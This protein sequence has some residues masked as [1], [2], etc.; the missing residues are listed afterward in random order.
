MITTNPSLQNEKQSGNELNEMFQET[1][2]LTWR[3][4][5]Q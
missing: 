2:A 1:S 5:I 4:F 3:L